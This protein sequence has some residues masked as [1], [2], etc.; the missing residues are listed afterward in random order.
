MCGA[1]S[2][3][4]YRFWEK[5]QTRMDLEVRYMSGNQVINVEAATPPQ[6][7]QLHDACHHQASEPPPFLGGLG[8][9]AAAT[10]P[11]KSSTLSS[12]C[13]VPLCR[14]AASLDKDGVGLFCFCSSD[15]IQHHMRQSNSLYTYYCLLRLVFVC[16][17]HQTAPTNIANV[18]SRH[19]LPYQRPLLRHPLVAARSAPLPLS[20]TC[21]LMLAV[22]PSTVT[23]QDINPFFRSECAKCFACTLE[24]PVEGPSDLTSCTR[25]QVSFSRPKGP[26]L[27][28][29]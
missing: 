19:R 6:A 17:I 16:A 1:A 5:K 20:R 10:I 27:T 4:T 8:L 18:F 3:T 26:I 9:F 25:R 11:T 14:C 12:A 29:A 24:R 2:R 13:A 28:N 22:S 21:L 23:V 15:A 7:A